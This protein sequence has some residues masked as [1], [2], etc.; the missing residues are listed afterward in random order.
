[1]LA[2]RMAKKKMEEKVKKT[3]VKRTAVQAGK[4]SKEVKKTVQTAKGAQAK[5]KDGQKRVADAVTR[6]QLLALAHEGTAESLRRLDEF[7]GSIEDQELQDWAMLAYHEANLLYYTPQNDEEERELLIAKLIFEHEERLIDLLEDIDHLRLSVKKQEIES[8]V[9]SRLGVT[10][11]KSQEEKEADEWA[12]GYLLEEDKRALE[13][14]E[15]QI[16][17]E[18]AWIDEA[19][20]MITVERYKTVPPI[21][22]EFFHFD[23]EETGEEDGVWDD[24]DCCCGEDCCGDDCCCDEDCEECR[25][26]RD[27]AD[28]DDV[29]F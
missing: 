29:P 3:V 15:E 7:M 2:T 24:D 18:E 14:T 8:E 11:K 12:E 16:R 13:E 27:H 4:N 22:W 26:H 9:E 21:F 5:K 28:M 20:K 17:H 6:E 25:T 10:Q 23:G 1:M 19:R